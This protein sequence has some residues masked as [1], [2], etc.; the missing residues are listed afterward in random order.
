[1]KIAIFHNFIL[2]NISCFLFRKR[3]CIMKIGV[4]NPAFGIAPEVG[5]T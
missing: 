5:N 2:C 1:M 4:E 3:Y